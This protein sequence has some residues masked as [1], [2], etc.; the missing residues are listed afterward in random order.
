M[1]MP[2]LKLS[3][4][5]TGTDMA[6]ENKWTTILEMETIPVACYICGAESEFH[7]SS[8]SVRHALETASYIQS[9]M[10]E[11]ELLQ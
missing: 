1:G 6:I 9:Y 2:T 5:R 4:P 10:R 8:E 11:I 7:S 3:Q